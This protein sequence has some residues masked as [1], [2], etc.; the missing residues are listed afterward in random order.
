MTIDIR[1]LIITDI[2]DV[3]A[4][5]SLAFARP[6]GE[7]AYRAQL[8]QEHTEWLVAVLPNSE[9]VI[10]F[11]GWQKL[12]DE[13]EILNFAVHPEHRRLGVGLKLFSRAIDEISQHSH[14]IFLEVRASNLAAIKIY[15]ACG[16]TKSGLRPNYYRDNLED[17]LLMQRTIDSKLI[18][19]DH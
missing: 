4:I 19:K 10:S 5:D 9:K 17:A 8:T 15:Q 18:H 14:T 2:A 12:G 1:P 16:F 13:A 6:W 7:A 3:V 11:V